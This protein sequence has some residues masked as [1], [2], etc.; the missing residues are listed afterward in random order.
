MAVATA[1]LAALQFAG[2][3][4]SA[5]AERELGKTRRVVSETNERLADLKAEAAKGRGREALARSRQKFKRLLG[6]QR[7]ALAASGVDIGTGSAQDIQKETQVMSELDAL[8]IKTNAAREVFGFKTQASQFAAEGKQA[9]RASK[10]S[11]MN[12]LLTGGLQAASM[13]SGG[14]G[15]GNRRVAGGGTSPYFTEQVGAYGPVNR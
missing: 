2:T 1:G 10:I 12:T 5:F 15:L 11:A 14:F 6:K 7:A 4:G 8:T 9:D 3:L 13:L